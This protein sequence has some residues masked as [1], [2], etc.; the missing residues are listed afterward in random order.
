MYLEKLNYITF[1]VEN[2]ESKQNHKE[3]NKKYPQ[4][5]IFVLDLYF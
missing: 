1:I 2:L 3:Q 4:S 5:R